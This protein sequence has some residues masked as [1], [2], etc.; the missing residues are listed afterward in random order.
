MAR[1]VP[2]IYPNDIA[3]HIPVG[4]GFPLNVSSPV[5]NYTTKA[6]VHDNLRNLILTMKGERP[7]QPEFGSDL[8]FLLFEQLY[9]DDLSKAAYKSIKASIRDWMPFVTLGTV[10]VTSYKE[11]S[12]VLIEVSY[13]IQGWDADDTLNITVKV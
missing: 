13:S 2:K 6:Q 5:M 11:T 1:L 4:M 12:S 10:S 9:D 3:E 7:M 8:Y